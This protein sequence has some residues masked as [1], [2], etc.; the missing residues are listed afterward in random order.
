MPQ[1]ET[2]SMPQRETESMPQRA[3]ASTPSEV[4]RDYKRK[5]C[6]HMKKVFDERECYDFGRGD[7]V[8]HETPPPVII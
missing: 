7:V 3:M 5:V 4:V 6:V 2:A 8:T 1:R